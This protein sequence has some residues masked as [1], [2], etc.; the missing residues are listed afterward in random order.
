MA[1]VR[2]DVTGRIE[3]VHRAR[4]AEAVEYLDAADPELTAFLRDEFGPAAGTP[5]PASL[6]PILEEVLRLLLAKG[7]VTID[8][9]STQAQA[10][11]SRFLEDQRADRAARFSA[12]GFVEVIDD[13]AFGSLADPP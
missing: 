3:S 8:E 11:W 13:S 5:D 9:L 12:S 10:T 4:T 6:L 1:Y 2:R 7:L